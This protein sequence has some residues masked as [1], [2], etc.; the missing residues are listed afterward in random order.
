[1]VKSPD[2]P[3]AI[4][5]LWPTIKN[6]SFIVWIG[7]GLS[8]NVD[9]PGWVDTIKE[10]CSKCDI[11]FPDESADW[12]SEILINKAE[13]CKIKDIDMYHSTL[14]DLFGKPVSSTRSAYYSLMNIPFKAYVTT[15]FDPLLSE[16]GAF[17][18]DRKIH[19]YPFLPPEFEFVQPIFYIHGL[20]RKGDQ[21]TGKNLILA[22][23]D[24]NEAYED[25]GIVKNFVVDIFT[26]HP[27][28]FLGCSLSEPE[29]FKAF[30][31]VHNIHA[32]FKR[33]NPELDLPKKFIIL[34]IRQRLI[35]SKSSGEKIERD[36][37]KEL[38]EFKRYEDMGIEV[39]R[40]EP[41]DWKNHAEIDEFLRKLCTCNRKYASPTP[42][43]IFEEEVTI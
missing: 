37:E 21:A 23:S 15:N 32:I 14:A 2:F 38:E 10:L 18:V 12:T 27:L 3:E 33:T 22:H 6:G 42:K 36:N 43:I 1:M 4:S 7:S 26:Y 35:R 40:Y 20:A 39:I 24:F 5:K 34:P 11:P 16:A 8:K 28:L 25:P 30:Q 17:N 19:S 31:K 13:E 9:Y 41:N 29:M